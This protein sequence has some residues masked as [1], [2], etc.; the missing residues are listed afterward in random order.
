[1]GFSILPK[2]IVLQHLSRQ[3]GRELNQYTL[4]GLQIH[5]TDTGDAPISDYETNSDIF[6]ALHKLGEAHIFVI[7]LQVGF[8]ISPAEEIANVSLLR[9]QAVQFAY[10]KNCDKL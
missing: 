5:F 9:L 10:R 6:M 8:Y 3:A 7:I 1:M 4:W 2:P